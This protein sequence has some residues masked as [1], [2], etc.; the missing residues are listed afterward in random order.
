MKK[1][2][3]AFAGMS[4]A[5]AA[6]ISIAS[7]AQPGE[8]ELDL[9]MTRNP[10][11]QNGAALYATCAACH[12][13]NGEGITDGSVPSLVGQ[14]YTVIAAQIVAFR[15]GTRGDPRMVHFS[16][17]RHLS[18]S[19][20]IADVAAYIARLKPIEAKRSTPPSD[21]SRAAL[22]YARS[23]E[24]C[25]GSAA[26]GK[27]DPGTPRLASQHFE[28]LVKQLDD[29]AAGHRVTMA[30]AHAALPTSLTRDQLVSIARYLASLAP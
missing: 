5:V 22:G 13:P 14:P 2:F 7:G 12:G 26:E 29:A 9:V 16:D 15:A 6:T 4:A 3:I 11:L 28:Y 30:N 23:C 18:F 25:H 10:D 27:E 24:R 17:R 1:R 21:D 19:Q 8:R 20:P